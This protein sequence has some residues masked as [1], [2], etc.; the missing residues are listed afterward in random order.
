[1]DMFYAAV[2]MRDN[3]ELRDKPIAVGNRGMLATSNYHARKF[4]VR[5]AMPGFVAEQL[6]P[7]LIIVPA[8]HGKYELIGKVIR[9]I[10][11]HYDPHF[12]SYG[13]DEAYLHVTPYMRA[14][15]LEGEAGAQ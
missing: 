8:N 10:V 6:C 15:G 11:K 9:S 13:L 12:E 3:P 2:E 7:D 1:M 4:G 14:H 5:S